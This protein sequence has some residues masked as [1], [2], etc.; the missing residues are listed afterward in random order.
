MGLAAIAIRPVVAD[1]DQT[2]AVTGPVFTQRFGPEVQTAR[3]TGA[4][5][6]NQPARDRR[7]AA[8]S[9]KRSRIALC[10]PSARRPGD[11]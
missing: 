2:R 9:R 10:A 1:P 6:N 8:T 11:R 7:G 5:N 3:N 4:G